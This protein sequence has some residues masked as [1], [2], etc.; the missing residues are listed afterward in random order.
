MRKGTSSRRF[1]SVV[2][3]LAAGALSAV[4]AC[5]PLDEDVAMLE[6]PAI[7]DIQ[8][9]FDEALACLKGKINPAITFGVGGI[10]DQTGTYQ[11]SDQ[12]TGRFVTQGA[13]DIVQSSLFKA[14]VT[15][16]NRRDMG[17]T[18]MESQWG[19]L[20][21][22]EQRP[23][24]F[25]ITGSINSLDF[26]P[27][28][29]GLLEVGG[30]GGTMR[31]YRILVGFDLAMTNVRTGRIVANIALSKQIVAD[32]KGMT[33]GRVVGDQIVE[34]DFGGSKREAVNFALRQMLQFGTYE[35]LTQMMPAQKYRDCADAINS[36]Y[37]EVTGD[38]TGG[39]QLASLLEQEAAA[40]AA[41]AA[42]AA[43]AAADG[44]SDPEVVPSATPVP[45]SAVQVEPIDDQASA[46]PETLTLPVI[47]AR[48][49]QQTAQTTTG[50]EVGSAE[51]L[52][53]MAVPNV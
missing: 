42:E 9:P 13:G 35:L 52:L 36:R 51:Y 33:F 10:P 22:A 28:G 53:Q 31:Q 46:A 14:G 48:A 5:A 44:L 34:M 29:G 25:V 18:A 26:I 24:N 30:V 39:G 47:P 16:I 23:V 41:E 50:A 3:L 15:L 20:D 17:T 12:G 2:K 37:G 32:E 40:M 6:G 45:S 43:P 27:G 7:T 21:L 11:N 49:E 38:M 4:A 8:T 19:L 1:R